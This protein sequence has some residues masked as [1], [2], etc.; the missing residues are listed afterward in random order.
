MGLALELDARLQGWPDYVAEAVD[1]C[2]GGEG[3]HPMVRAL[4][5]DITANDEQL[6]VLKQA[7]WEVRGPFFHLLAALLISSRFFHCLILLLVPPLWCSSC[8]SLSFPCPPRFPLSVLLL[9]LIISLLLVRVPLL[10]SRLLPLPSPPPTP[11]PLP[12]S[13]GLLPS[14]LCSLVLRGSFWGTYPEQEN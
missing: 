10:L 11:P 9:V 7:L 12:L 2:E 4:V 14:P 1:Y 13:R 5:I 6:D 3:P 8:S